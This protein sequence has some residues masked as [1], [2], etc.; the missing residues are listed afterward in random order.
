MKSVKMSPLRA[1]IGPGLLMAAAAI[2][3][4]H[5]VQATRAGADY[6]LLLLP[7]LLLA[8]LLKYPFL[9]F[10]PRYA[11]ATGNN[12]LVGYLRIGRWALA[13]FALITVATMFIILAAVTMVTAGLAGLVFGIDASPAVISAGVLVACVG[14]LA[15]GDYRG[16]DLAMKMI[17]ASLTVLTLV[18]LA[19]ALGKGPDWAVITGVDHLPQ[20]WTLAGVGF[21]LALIG[22]MPIPLDASVWHSIWTQERARETGQAP[23]VRNAIF[24]FN[25]GYIAATGLA[26]VFLLLGALMMYASGL[27][28]ADSPVRFAGQLVDIY[29]MVLGEWSRPLIAA[30]ALI[31]MFSTTLAVIDAYPRVLTA[32]AAIIRHGHDRVHKPA[33]MSHP[34]YL[35]FLVILLAGALLILFFSGNRF[36]QLID[37]ATLLSFLAAPLFA[38]LNLKAVTSEHMPVAARPGP[39]MLALSWASLIA[40]V[41]VALL[42]LGWWLIS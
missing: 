4:S 26:A 5:L 8:C 36:K 21:L 41:V 25:L 1:A 12:L 38:W 22:W 29:G 2:G 13:L 34:L 10:G 35:V 20:L 33:R 42:W 9:E 18:A 24:D 27:Q 28:F 15:I 32:L 17:M 31:T 16:L 30:I 23:T 39:A 6:G 37:L 14:F 11:A 40:G 19:L 7:L 3:V